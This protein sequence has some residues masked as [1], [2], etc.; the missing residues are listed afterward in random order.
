[1]DL[2][3]DWNNRY[4][5]WSGLIG[6]TFLALAYFGCDQSQVQRYLTGKSI[7]QSKLSLLFNAMAKIPMQFFILFVG[8]M[9]FVFY[10]FERPPLLFQTRGDAGAAFDGA[11]AQYAPIEVAL[12][13][14][15][16]SGAKQRRSGWPRRAAQAMT[17]Q[18][19]R[20]SRAATGRAAGD[21]WRARRREPVCTRSAHGEK[22]FNDTNYIFLSFVTRYLPAGVVGLV[23]AVIFAAAMS[24][25]SGEVNSLATVTRDRHL[26][27]AHA[28]RT[29][30]TAHYLLGFASGDGVL[31]R[32]TR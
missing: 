20:V 14:R 17:R 26:Q 6:G 3:F 28:P 8:A 9:V 18:A 16:R 2:K 25:S 29:R 23:I 11:G 1:M 22:G 31:G 4:N 30:R 32:R 7:A 15:V 24:A 21:R 19:R 10:L 12:R 27:A 13:A 5:V